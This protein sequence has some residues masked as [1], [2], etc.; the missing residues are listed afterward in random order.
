[1][2]LMKKLVLMTIIL[3]LAATAHAAEGE[4]DQRPRW[5]IEIK[6]G[7]FYPDFNNW[8][9]YYGGRKTW[10]V[11]GAV[12][13]K[14]FRQVEVGVEAGMMRDSGQ[15]FAPTM[16][17]LSGR[18]E[19]TLWPLN[20]YA[21]YRAVFSEN[22]WLVPYAGGGWTRMFYQEKIEGQSTV[23]GSADG[24]HGRAGI[25]LLLDDLD[26]GAANNLFLDFGIRH[27][28][29]IFEVEYS[30]VMTTTQPSVTDP[31]GHEVNLGGTSYLGGFLFEF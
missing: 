27:T 31:S 6:G 20:L 25:Q 26:S 24:Y 15:A 7:Y 11:A 1:M 23:K 10:D 3:M 2:N 13:Y 8:Q 4:L 29:L 17:I 28:Y 18:V 19:Y 12:G 9:W 22:Q 30:K 21:L 16:N 5:A 14:I